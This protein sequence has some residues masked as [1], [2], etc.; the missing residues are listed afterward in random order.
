MRNL[1][2]RQLLEIRR[3]AHEAY[4]RRRLWPRRAT[5]TIEGRHAVVRTAGGILLRFPRDS[6]LE[7]DCIRR[8]GF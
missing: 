1:T 2:K 6:L 3:A 7:P 8:L 4:L 5:L